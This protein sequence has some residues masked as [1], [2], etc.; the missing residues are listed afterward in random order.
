MHTNLF[1]YL[2]LY[3]MDFL[4]ISLF[5]ALLGLSS[6]IW[7]SIFAQERE[8]NLGEVLIR[9]C[10]DPRMAGGTKSLNLRTETNRE[11]E[12][13]MYL[14]N[15][16]PKSVKVGVNFVDGTITADSEGKKACQPEGV[17]TN[18]WQY[19]SIE[20]TGFII[21]SNWTLKTKAILKFPTGIAGKVNGCVTYQILSDSTGEQLGMFRILSRRA[22]FI[23]VIVSWEVTFDVFY[24]AEN[25][26]SFPNIGQNENV[27]LYL[28]PISK[29]YS[30]KSLITNTGNIPSI[31]TI[32]GYINW[33]FGRLHQELSPKQITIPAKQ[34]SVYENDL[35][36]WVKFWGPVTVHLDATDKPELPEGIHAKELKVLTHEFVISAFILPWWIIVV[37]L[38]LLG[39]I[40]YYTVR[41]NKQKQ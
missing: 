3:T 8:T 2:Q 30:L 7:L 13:C 24:M 39:L 41:W 23:D 16:W 29:Y 25:N 14:D 26:P 28:H 6:M 11:E 1:I 20:S 40:T 4:R 35:P 33:W 9:F 5:T 38:G 27:T 32:S 22:N 18:F 10:N 31:T 17:R 15:S 12:I 37:L 21:P 34:Q 19:V 36:R